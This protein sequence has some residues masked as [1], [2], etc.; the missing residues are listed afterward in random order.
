VSKSL[1]NVVRIRPWIVEGGRHGETGARLRPDVLRL[2]VSSVDLFRDVPLGPGI[3]N[4][5]PM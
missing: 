4:S 2:V 5:W 3:V 1:G